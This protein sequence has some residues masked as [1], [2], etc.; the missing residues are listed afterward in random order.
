M[1]SSPTQSDPSGF[2]LVRI[3]K[4]GFKSRF[5]KFLDRIVGEGRWNL[6]DIKEFQQW[7]SH[8]DYAFKGRKWKEVFKSGAK[9]VGEGS[10]IS[11]ALSKDQPAGGINLADIRRELEAGRFRKPGS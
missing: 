1:S 3:D 11:T 2:D 4:A 9:I 8:E 10:Q 5:R 7:L 6:D